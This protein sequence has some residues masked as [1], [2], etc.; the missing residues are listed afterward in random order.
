MRLSLYYN[1]ATSKS[2]CKTDQARY[3]LCIKADAL[4][5]FGHA[6]GFFHE[7]ERGDYSGPFCGAV[8]QKLAGRKYGAY[9]QRSIMSY[10]SDGVN[11]TRAWDTI[12]PND[13]A[14]AQ[15]AYGRRIK[16]QV[17]SDNGYCVA[18]NGFNPGNPGPRAFLWTCDEAADDQE[19][20][21]TPSG[22]RLLGHISPAAGSSACITN[23]D[24]RINDCNSSLS[25]SFRIV[26]TAI[27][28]WGGLCMDLDGGNQASGTVI[29][30]WECL[31]NDNQL[32]NISD[33]G[34][35]KLAANTNK[36]ITVQNGATANGT[37]L[38][39]GT[40]TGASS[41]KFTFSGGRIGFGGKCIDS[42][43]VSDAD[44]TNDTQGNDGPS[45]GWGAQL[46]DCQSAQRNQL[47][48]FSGAF[49]SALGSV[50]IDRNAGDGNGVNMTTETC[51]FSGS[52]TWDYYF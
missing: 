18:A 30:S 19:W 5:E 35:I 41:Q 7:E 24:I 23:G 6:I 43:A 45:N 31:D 37:P 25:Q 16:G 47:W 14:A 17:V 9:D 38:V 39:I 48:N 21:W 33:V 34:E 10:C 52:Q 13:I 3:E 29:Q 32:W 51:D 49:Q 26:K 46:W 4:H 20:S 2:V 50:C 27:R 42:P 12:S 11:G 22:H 40:C 8:A 36:C 28:G 15:R 44:Y 1:D